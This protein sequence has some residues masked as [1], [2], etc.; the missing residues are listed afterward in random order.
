LYV[1]DLE[2]VGAERRRELDD[3]VEAL[4]VLP[5][6][7]GVHRQGQPRLADKTRNTALRLLRSGKARDAVARCNIEIL[8]AQLHVL[9]PGLN[10]GTEPI[11]IK[12]NARRDQIAVKPR[13]GSMAHEVDKVA[14]DEG[15]TAGEVHLQHAQ[16]RGF[17]EDPFPSRGVEFGAGACKL[18]RI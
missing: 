14:P 2:A 17:A 13:F 8:Q 9:K 12:A 15:L 1:S 10:Q 7:D 16:F 18:E 5:V 6:H 3:L 4:E 11:G